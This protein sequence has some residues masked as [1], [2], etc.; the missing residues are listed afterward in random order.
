[1]TVHKNL[2]P[3]DEF[4]RSRRPTRSDVPAPNGIAC[5]DCGGE[6][7]DSSPGLILTSSPPQKNVH[8]PACHYRG[9]RVA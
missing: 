7:W 8:C 1:M 3:L 5:P 9:F 6:L 2:T 4:N